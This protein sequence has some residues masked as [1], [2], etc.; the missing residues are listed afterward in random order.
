[1]AAAAVLVYL[2]AFGHEF[3]LDDTRI[4]RDNLRIR[5][6]GNIP[7]LFGTSYWGI[8]GA[9]SLY[10]PL[11]LATY[12]LNYA[13]QGLSTNGFTA[14]NVGLH[15]AV[16]VL[17]FALVRSLRASST[18]AG[19][20]GIAFAVHPVHTEAVT[21]I[22]GRPE[23]LAALFF[24][25][26]LLCYRKVTG[27]GQWGYRVAAWLSFACALLSK[28]SAITLLLVVPVMDALFPPKTTSDQSASI[29]FRLVRNY[30]PFLAVAAAYL[31]VR[32]TVLDSITISEGV[33]APLDNPL[34]P[35]STMALGER[36]GATG[37]EA[38]MTPFAVVVEYARLLIWPVRL[39]P[40]YSYNQIPLVV[41]AM[42]LRFIS[43]LALVAGCIYGIAALW[44][45]YPLAA[46]SLAFLV[47]T[48]SVVSNV[49]ITIGTICAERLMYLPSAGFLMAAAAGV[50][51]VIER[52]PALRRATYGGVAVLCVLGAIRT[53]TRNPDWKNDFALWSSAIAAAPDS[54]RVQSEY[55]RVLMT[56]AESDATAGRTTDAD[57]HF[58][59]AQKHFE[60]ALALYPSYAPP[61]DGLATI[62][63][64]HQRYDEALVLFERA[65]KAWPAGSFTSLTNWAG[66]LWDRSSREA[67]QATALREQGRA[68]EA[69]ALAERADAG[70]RQAVDK[71]NQA[72]ALSPSYAHA[73]LIRALL[74]DGYVHD[75]PGAIKEFEEVLRLAPAHPQRPDIERELARLRAAAHG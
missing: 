1:V 60:R 65:V 20:V 34:V 50:E 47:L 12:A 38:L 46:F 40:D 66:L 64:E 55:G 14:V 8:A 54:A 68:A 45:R 2:N 33:I 6:L 70:F 39:S 44:R 4:I 41:N 10:R 30:L 61:M 73:H 19:I 48:F 32:Q 52:K 63:A 16:S 26:S 29:R 35:I 17:L 36:L 58:A 42:D 22:A 25:I 67:Q 31:V 43:G 23:L 74:L 11:V 75:Q 18:V 21:G 72:I 56:Q 27:S 71:V 13:L 9:Q 51:W 57:Q 69:D 59:E 7:E 15:A 62:F 3:V 5:S 53:W 24:L 49:V 37:R 28:E